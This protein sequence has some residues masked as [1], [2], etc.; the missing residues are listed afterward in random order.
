MRMVMIVLDWRVSRNA[1]GLSEYG[2]SLPSPLPSLLVYVLALG[3]TC[4]TTRLQ[5]DTAGGTGLKINSS[6]DLI[7]LVGVTIL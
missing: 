3:S 5:R 4:V 6:Y 2:L 1:E 7:N